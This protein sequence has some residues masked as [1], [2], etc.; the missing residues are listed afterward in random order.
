MRGSLGCQHP[1]LFSGTDNEESRCGSRF[2]CRISHS[3]ETKEIHARRMST[4]NG[5]F[6]NF[7]ASLTTD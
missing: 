7:D 4:T 6:S 1:K 2:Q 3:R 5:R